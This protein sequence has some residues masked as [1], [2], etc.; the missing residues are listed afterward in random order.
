MSFTYRLIWNLGHFPCNP[1]QKQSECW[2]VFLKSQNA[3]VNQKPFNR[4]QNYEWMCTKG[5][6][7]TTTMSNLDNLQ[8][9]DIDEFLDD[10]WETG[11][12]IFN[13]TFSDQDTTMEIEFG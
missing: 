13:V 5:C 8:F 2:P 10:S 1:T 12:G 3:H 6:N 7:K 4:W 11:V 9:T